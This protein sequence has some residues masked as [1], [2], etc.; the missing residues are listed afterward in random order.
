MAAGR[1]ASYH[2]GE[3]LQKFLAETNSGLAE[4]DWKVT[5][6]RFAP[7]APEQN[8]TEDVWLKGKTYLRK[9]FAV[10]KTLLSVSMKIAHLSNASD[11]FS[12]AFVLLH[13]Y[14]DMSKLPT[15]NTASPPF[16][17]RSA[18]PQRSSAG[19]GQRNK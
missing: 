6:M 19:T 7:N 17:I 3:E 4:A 1:R 9:Q 8:P 10:N 12:G 13:L 15:S 14:S 2:R 18:L 16:S 11:G 5:C